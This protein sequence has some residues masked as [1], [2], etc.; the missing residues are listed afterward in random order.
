M[1]K[2]L[3]FTVNVSVRF[4]PSKQVFAVIALSDKKHSLLQRVIFSDLYNLYLMYLI[5]M[6]NKE[7]H[8]YRL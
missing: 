1:L 6:T 8:L 2:F 4:F 3:L 5:I 7:C